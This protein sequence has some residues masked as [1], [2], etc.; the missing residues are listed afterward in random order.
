L[1]VYGYVLE[2]I[3]PLIVLRAPLEIPVPRSEL[4]Y[5]RQEGA[6]QEQ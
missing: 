3:R 2:E 4:G 6:R 5:F 1:P